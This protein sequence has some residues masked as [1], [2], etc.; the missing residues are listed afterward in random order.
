MSCNKPYL[1]TTGFFDNQSHNSEDMMGICDQSKILNINYFNSTK[2]SNLYTI[3][4][5]KALNIDYASFPSI[6][7]ME[8]FTTGGP[9]GKDN[10]HGYC[11]DG[12]TYKNGKC[13]QLCTGC[14]YSDRTNNKSQEFNEFDKCFSEGVFNGFTNEGVTT[15]TCGKNGQYCSGNFL[16]RLYTADGMFFN[17]NDLIVNIANA[18]DME[19]YA[20]FE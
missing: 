12:F 9:P 4:A 14:K 5:S 6:P 11:P 16:D 2:P 15:C 19:N 1:D 17:H 7:F 10:R 20:L 18:N 3:N 8:G 13:E